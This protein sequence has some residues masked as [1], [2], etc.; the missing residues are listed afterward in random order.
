MTARE[1]YECACAFL[2]EQAGYDADF[3]ANALTLINT[4]MEECL[5]WEN[6]IRAYSYQPELESAPRLESLD[7]EIPYALSI[8]RV[9]LPYGLASLF[10]QDECDDYKAQDYRG[11]YINALREACK[12]VEGEIV[13]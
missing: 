10:Y 1:V 2:F 13:M 5:A 4:L 6:S 3:H 9:A 12:A 8:A 11:R 7:D